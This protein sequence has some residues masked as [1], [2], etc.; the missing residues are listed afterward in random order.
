MFYDQMIYKGTKD[1]SFIFRAYFVDFL[2]AVVCTFQTLKK[3]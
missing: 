2:I 3:K 1:F